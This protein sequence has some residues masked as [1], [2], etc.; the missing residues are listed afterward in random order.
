[1]WV[2][3]LITGTRTSD[4]TCLLQDNFPL[5]IFCL[6]FPLTLIVHWK[7]NLHHCCDFWSLTWKHCGTNWSRKR[8]GA[9]RSFQRLSLYSRWESVSFQTKVVSMKGRL[10]DRGQHNTGRI[11]RMPQIFTYWGLGGVIN[12]CSFNLIKCTNIEFKKKTNIL[13]SS[14]I[15]GKN[16][17][18]CRKDARVQAKFGVSYVML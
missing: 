4:I 2:N 11:K 1:M 3:N 13:F 5:K 9:G 10:K 6:I 12:C 7:K 17:H 8:P 16:R 15:L 18:K 14:I